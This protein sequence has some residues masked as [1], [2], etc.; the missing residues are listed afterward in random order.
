MLKLEPKLKLKAPK[1]RK[2]LR[3]GKPMAREGGPKVEGASAPKE[4][5]GSGAGDG[6]V[7]LRAPSAAD[8]VVEEVPRGERGSGLLGRE[9]IPTPPMSA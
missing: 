4:G 1:L 6:N 7:W 3:L 8:A 9:A 2:E 5:A